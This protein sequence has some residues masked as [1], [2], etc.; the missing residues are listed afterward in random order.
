METYNIPKSINNYY[1]KIQNNLYDYLVGSYTKFL[2]KDLFNSIE[3]NST[4]LDIGIGNGSSLVENSEII[5]KKN[6]K[7]IGIDI[8]PG[9]IYLAKETL[10]ENNLCDY[11]QVNCINVFEYEP[12]QKF[13]YI[14]FS[15][16]FSV[17]PEITKMLKDVKSRLLKNSGKIV[18]ATTIEDKSSNLK[19]IVKENAKKVALGIDFGRLTTICD[20]INKIGEVNMRISNMKLVYESWYPVWGD[21][22]IYSFYI[23]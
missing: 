17:I 15:N 21:I 23:E 1:S 9:A 12:D 2:Y 19:S 14:F 10:T 20:F 7:I 13:D 5:K 4:I 18:I 3:A 8:D 16:S 6:L 11:V 22:K